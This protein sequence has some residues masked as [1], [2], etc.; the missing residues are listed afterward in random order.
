MSR[1]RGW[2]G[3]RTI[4]VVNGAMVALL[5]LWLTY[6]RADTLH[7]MASVTVRCAAA[8]RRWYSY[9][10]AATRASTPSCVNLTSLPNIIISLRQIRSVKDVLPMFQD[11]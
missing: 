4:L 6:A 5:A 1:I 11:H 2:Q 7:G 10:V 8:D 9:T 3:V